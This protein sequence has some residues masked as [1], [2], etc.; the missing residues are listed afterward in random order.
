MCS[1]H[2]GVAALIDP[3]FAPEKFLVIAEEMGVKIQYVFNTHGHE[4]HTNGNETVLKKTDAILVGFGVNGRNTISVQDG[5]EIQLGSTV[6]RI[7]HT[8]G[9]TDDSITIFADNNI[10]T[11]DTLFVGRVGSTKFREDARKQYDSLKR[12]LVEL[13]DD[14]DMFPGHDVG[15]RPFSTLRYER[16]NNPFLNAKDFNEFIYLKRF[17]AKREKEKSERLQAVSR[18]KS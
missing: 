1:E 16:D 5:S 14:A 15:V 6:V 9:H 11:G 13:P 3:S 2:E 10:V 17:W 12:L 8:P 18:P 4:D 7:L